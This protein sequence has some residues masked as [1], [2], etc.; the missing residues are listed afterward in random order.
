MN[1]YIK[2]KL[3]GSLIC[4]IIGLLIIFLAIV[5]NK[6]QSLIFSLMV[7]PGIWGSMLVL[8]A[9]VLFMEVCLEILK[10]FFGN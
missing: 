6:Q 7:H 1:I 2:K 4:L 8:F 5:Q 10:N 9:W 3:W